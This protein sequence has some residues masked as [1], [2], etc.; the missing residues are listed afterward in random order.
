VTFVED[1]LRRVTPDVDGLDCERD[2]RRVSALRRSVLLGSTAR[3]SSR[4]RATCASLAGVSIAGRSSTPVYRP[5]TGRKEWT[6]PRPPAVGGSRD[7]RPSTCIDEPDRPRRQLGLGHNATARSDTERDPVDIARPIPPSAVAK[8]D[9]E[10]RDGR[11]PHVFSPYPPA[12]ARGEERPRPSHC[13]KVAARWG[14]CGKVRLVNAELSAM[15][16]DR[17]RILDLAESS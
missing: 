5:R 6:R 1:A 13:A 4:R 14:V 11:R 3:R 16:T 7:R 12:R 2:A 15:P 10:P 17:N 8:A 9:H